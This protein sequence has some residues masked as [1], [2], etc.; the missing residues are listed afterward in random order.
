MAGL[1][2]IVVPTYNESE[3]ITDLLTGLTERFPGFQILVVDDNSPD[4]TG[5]LAKELAKKLNNIRVIHRTEKQGL[6]PAYIAGFREAKAIGAS[7]IIAMDAD[8]SHRLEDLELMLRAAESTDLIIGS[9]WIPGGQV[10]NWNRFRRMLS[11]TA[12]RYAKFMLRSKVRDLTSGFRIYITDALSHLDFNRVASHGYCF[13]IETAWQL[14]RS[15]ASIQQV[16]IDFVER[17]AGKSK[18]SFMIALE[19]VLRITAWAITRPSKLLAN[20]AGL[21]KTDS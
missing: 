2:A 4:G 12:N 14:E 20:D 21:S 10:T 7:R 3:N 5:D 9:R 8:G 6:G 15:G 11:R 19:A 17:A 1:T 13:Q 18:M 16:P